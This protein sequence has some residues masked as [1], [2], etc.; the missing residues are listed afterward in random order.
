MINYK[1]IEPLHQSEQGSIVLK[2]KNT[3]TGE[4][5]VL[6]LI[7]TSEKNVTMSRAKSKE[8]LKQRKVTFQTPLKW[9]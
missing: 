1:S 2:V 9:L 5:C 4:I 6:K 3:D 7:L 8:P